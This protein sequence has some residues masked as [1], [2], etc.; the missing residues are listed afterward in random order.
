M[1]EEDLSGNIIA[2]LNGDKFYSHL[3]RDLNLIV[4][5]RNDKFYINLS[6]MV[7][8][9]KKDDRKFNELVKSKCFKDYLKFYI[10]LHNIELNFELEINSVSDLTELL[11]EL[12]FSINTNMPKIKGCY[13]PSD[14]VDFILFKI[15][16]E[17]SYQVHNLLQTIQD[18]ADITNK[19]FIETLT[20]EINDLKDENLK[21]KQTVNYDKDYIEELKDYNNELYERVERYLEKLN[22]PKSITSDRKKEINELIGLNR[23]PPNFNQ[24][25]PLDR[26]DV[27]SVLTL[28]ISKEDLRFT[29]NN[30]RIYFK[31]EPEDKIADLNMDQLKILTLKSKHKISLLGTFKYK[32]NTVSL[33][34]TSFLIKRNYLSSFLEE[35]IIHIKEKKFEDDLL[36]IDTEFYEK[37]IN[38]TYIKEELERYLIYIDRSYRELSFIDLKICYNYKKQTKVI[39]TNSLINCR[40]RNKNNKLLGNITNITINEDK[41]EILY[42]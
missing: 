36:S 28:Y 30:I 9:I 16:P 6:N 15:K 33:D 37:Y 2:T 1:I 14:L 39:D 8:F 38:Q 19:S 42:S 32:F 12:F 3:I 10:N 41:C 21:L 5:K 24:V 18:K 31:I 26:S 40:I 20:D 4:T 34:S 11:P 29:E 17:Y 13:G 23:E 35:F 7:N 25:T 22:R 27:T